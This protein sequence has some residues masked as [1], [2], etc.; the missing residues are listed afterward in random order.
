M[1]YYTI[2]LVGQMT[3]NPETFSWRQRVANYFFDNSNIH[4]IDPGSSLFDRHLLRASKENNQLFNSQAIA[5]DARLLVAKDRYYVKTANCLFINL[6]VYTPERPILGSY[7]ELAWAYDCPEKMK[8]GIYTGDR[9]KAFHCM[10]PFVDQ[11]IQT[12]VQDE[13]EACK[14]LEYHVHNKIFVPEDVLDE[15]VT[16]KS[17]Q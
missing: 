7:F 5:T 3:S 13:I 16:K 9:T 12:W 8:I 11:A 15:R 6:N 4:V 1:V 10:H 2:Y 17:A 14:L